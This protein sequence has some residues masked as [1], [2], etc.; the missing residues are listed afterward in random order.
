MPASNGIQLSKTTVENFTIELTADQVQAACVQFALG[1]RKCNKNDV[2]LQEW[3]AS[4]GGGVIISVTVEP[5]TEKG[6]SNAKA[7][8]ETA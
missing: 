3:K 2:T 7:E 8:E 1:A 5:K 4:K 6:E